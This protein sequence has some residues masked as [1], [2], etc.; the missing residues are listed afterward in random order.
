ML[1]LE[2][3][4]GE[5]FANRLIDDGSFVIAVGRRKENLE[6]LVQKHGHDKCQAVPFD[7]TKLDSVPHFATNIM[8]THPNIDCKLTLVP[9]RCFLH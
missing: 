2:K 4:I 7:I 1:T 6:T 8:N 5:A 9:L 3:G